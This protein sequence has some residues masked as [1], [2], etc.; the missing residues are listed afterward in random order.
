V[1]HDP[2][3]GAAVDATGRRPDT[4]AVLPTEPRTDTG[5]PE[6]AERWR[7]WS[8]LAPGRQRRIALL[9]LGDLLC[10]DESV[11]RLCLP[12]WSRTILRRRHCRRAGRHSPPRCC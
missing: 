10:D 6:A 8:Q 12:P 5:D 1:N 11:E 7:R 3:A 9:L 4:D 2:I